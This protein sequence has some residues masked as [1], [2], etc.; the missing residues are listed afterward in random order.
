MDKRKR[1]S[2]SILVTGGTGFIG[3]HVAL[4]LLRRGYSVVLL[5]RRQKHLTAQERIHQLLDWFGATREE[6]S[7]LAVFEGH[8]D[9]PDLGLDRAHYDNLANTVDEIVHCASNTS[10]S[11]RKRE[12][13]EK[14]NVAN[15][16]NI[17]ALAAGSG[18]YFFHQVST[19]YVAG[20]RAG[21]CK[22]ELVETREFTN[23]YEETKYLAERII[24]ARCEREGIKLTIYRPSIVYG[25]SQSGRTI[26]FDGVYYPVRTVSFFKNLYEKD[27]NEHGGKKAHEMGV[28][29]DEK[30]RM[31]LPLRVEVTASGGIN[32]IPIDYFVRAFMAIMEDCLEGEV[33]HIVN[34]RIT[35]IEDLAEH[36]RRFFHIEGIQPVPRDAFTGAPRNG[37]E[38]L[39]DRYIEAYG[40]YMKDK[41][42]F[43][44]GK[45]EAIL[46]KR[47]I[48]CPDFDYEVFSRCM[49]YAVDV[50]WGTRLFNQTR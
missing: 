8:L 31:Y 15:L 40:P 20:K 7:R 13:V 44:N 37:L 45:T 43:K 16:E 19:A 50:D 49:Q 4:E 47:N 22:E 2:C 29:I 21:P 24:K 6:R 32:L 9:A 35:T 28:E 39:F 14:A 3:S 10:F 26:R 1:R 33:F 18:C 41:R 38:I 17:L 11:E 46:G 36:T 42:V 30:G 23:V 12:A 25:D 48:A 34:T 27:I 5:A